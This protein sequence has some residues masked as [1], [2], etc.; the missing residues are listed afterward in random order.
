MLRQILFNVHCLEHIVPGQDDETE[1]TTEGTSFVHG[2]PPQDGSAPPKPDSQVE[3]LHDKVTKQIIK[4]GQG[5]KPSKYS[6]CF[7]K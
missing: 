3:V 5:Q 6:T 4:D 1:I 2:E 7:G